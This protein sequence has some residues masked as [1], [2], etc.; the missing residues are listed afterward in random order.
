MKRLIISLIFILFS[1]LFSSCAGEIY[2]VKGEKMILKPMHFETVCKDKVAKVFLSLKSDPRCLKAEIV[3]GPWRGADK[4]IWHV[5][6]RGLF[7]EKGVKIWRWAREENNQ[8]VTSLRDDFNP[9]KLLHFDNLAEFDFFLINPSVYYMTA[10]QIDR[11]K[12]DQLLAKSQKNKIKKKIEIVKENT[13]KEK[14]RLKG[15]NNFEE[16]EIASLI[17]NLETERKLTVKEKIEE[18]RQSIR[19]SSIEKEKTEKQRTYQ[20]QKGDSLWKI[21]KNLVK[22]NGQNI[23]EINDVISLIAQENNICNPDLIM[24][25]QILKIP[26]IA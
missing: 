19:V 15:K 9:D 3:G 25:G 26:L 10:K 20:V 6:A 12:K 17:N 1:F 16:F 2:T 24:T 22:H 14:K 8:V 13:E 23:E 5:Q 21:S 7:E 4:T 18:L 11:E